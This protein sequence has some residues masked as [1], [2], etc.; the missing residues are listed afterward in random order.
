MIAMMLLSLVLIRAAGDTRAPKLPLGKDTTFVTGPLD[1]RGYIDYEAAL[2]AEFSKG[3]T[4]ERNSN[5]LILRV[6]GPKPEGSELMPSYYK[7]LDA[8]APPKDG[9]YFLDTYKFNRDFLRMS[10]EQMEALDEFQTRAAQR[11]WI[12]SDCPPLVEW[13]K[14]NEKPLALLIEATE[15][16]AYY[17]PLVSRR[18]EG[19]PSILIAALL[20]TVQ[21][22]RGLAQALAIRATLRIGEK[23]YDE[24]WRDILACHRLGRLVSRGATLIELIV[25]VAIGQMANNATLAYVD[26]ANLTSAQALARLKELQSLPPLASVVHKVNFGERM[27]G[28]DT[29]QVIRRG[30]PTGLGFTFET[31]RK[32]TVDER[33]S[34]ESIDWAAALKALNVWYDRLVAV[35]RIEDRAAR[36]KAFDIIEAEL[37][38]IKKGVGL[39]DSPLVALLQLVAKNGADRV[40]GKTV[41]DLV[42]TLLLP[43]IRR[44]QSFHDRIA[45]GDKNLGVAFA[46]AAHR[47]DHN[48]YPARL[49]DLAPK[50]LP[51]VPDDLFNG[52]PLIYKPS[53][54]GY[55]FYSVGANGKDDGGRWL[56][57]DPPGDDPGVRMPLP[58]LKKK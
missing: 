1:K 22:C 56:T 29:L 36:E 10:P 8:P 19:E 7:W 3:I 9:D 46:M 28:L 11:V 43:A 49:A 58:E 41:G 17:N 21:K 35:L 42:A 18:D 48:R 53:E 44:V 50:Y 26:R 30:D 27:M 34:L 2:N 33:K 37:A 47:A 25:G 55:L 31:D 12:A 6:L 14:V 40:V 5:V 57:D 4:P 13:L 20:P 15:L 51:G 32:L 45:Q 52:K 39:A 24:A 38:E 16:P 54:Q 23:K